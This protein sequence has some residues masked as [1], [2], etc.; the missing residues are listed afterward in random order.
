MCCRSKRLTTYRRSPID[1]Y[2]VT[3]RTHNRMQ[4]KTFGTTNS[5]RKRRSFLRVFGCQA[6]AQTAEESSQSVFSIWKSTTLV[7]PRGR[8][9]GPAFHHPVLLQHTFCFGVLWPENLLLAGWTISQYQACQLHKSSVCMSLS[10]GAGGHH[11]VAGCAK[12]GQDGPSPTVSRSPHS[13]PFLLH[14]AMQRLAHTLDLVWSLLK[15]ACARYYHLQPDVIHIPGR[16]ELQLC[17]ADS[18]YVRMMLVLPF[19]SVLHLFASVSF[20]TSRIH[21][22]LGPACVP[23]DRIY[24]DATKC[25]FPWMWC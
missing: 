18:M 12:I 15:R 21:V 20:F 25:M 7:G 5:A 11:L 14:I 17:S 8:E 16:L 4:D 1:S 24:Y 19:Q 6:R 23:S 2:I 10:I 22:R 3:D 13:T 9:P